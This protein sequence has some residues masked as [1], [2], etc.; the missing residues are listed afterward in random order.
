MATQQTP[1]L[2]IPL[3]VVQDSAG[4]HT[5]NEPGER[6]RENIIDDLCSGFLLQ[7]TLQGTVHGTLT[8][9]GDPATLLVMQFLFQ[10]HTAKRR[11]RTAEI[12]IKFADQKCPLDDDPEIIDLWPQGNF[13]F[14]PSEVDV[15]DS[16]GGS[17]TVSGG[18]PGASLELTG[19]WARS[20][21][22][23]RNHAASLRGA[24]RIEGRDWGKQNVV[25]ITLEENGDQKEGIIPAISTA[26]LLKRKDADA[27][28]TAQV[29]VQ[30]QADIRYATAMRIRDVSGKS[31]VTDPVVFDPTCQ[32]TLSVGDATHLEA[33]TLEAFATATSTTV[34]ST[35]KGV[36]GI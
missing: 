8:P 36:A 35:V 18:I 9:G 26:V 5:R 3:D 10:G 4:Y 12:K 14:N 34:L 32:Q 29:E 6:Q 25:R 24:R 23:K 31:P 17:A 13:T 30:A 33:E 11:F 27:C 21:G 22:K 20:T 19:N 1:L 7:A 15:N 16:K 28:F 2:T